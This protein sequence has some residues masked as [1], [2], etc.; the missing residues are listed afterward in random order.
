MQNTASNRLDGYGECGLA[1]YRTFRWKGVG[2]SVRGDV[3]NLGNKQYSI[4]KSY[5]MPGRS[6]RLTISMNL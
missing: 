4:V 6:Y 2:F 3:Q 1:L 5:P